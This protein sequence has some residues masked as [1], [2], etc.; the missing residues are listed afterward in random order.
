MPGKKKAKSSKAPPTTKRKARPEPPRERGEPRKKRPAQQ[1]GKG[2]QEPAGARLAGH[3][4]ARPAPEP[5]F[6]AV[7]PDDERAAK[8][9]VKRER[10]FY[11]AE[12]MACDRWRPKH[13]K[14]L[15][16]LWG[17]ATSTVQDMAG[18]ASRLLEF[19]TGKIERLEQLVKA[20][21]YEIQNENGD[22]RVQ[23]LKL[24]S[25]VCGLLRQRVDVQHSGKE[26]GPVQAVLVLPAKDIPPHDP[27]PATD[28]SP[29]DA[30]SA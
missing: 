20:R 29:G 11:I 8:A 2:R 25:E 19:A 30:P 10:V 5:E 13:A 22:D 27:S 3:A 18:E 24:L 6:E 28:T 26:G 14:E 23:A 12:E 17:L 7:D 21:L 16:E 15:G 1:V 4:R 9:A